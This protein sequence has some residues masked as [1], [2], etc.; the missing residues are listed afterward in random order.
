MASARLMA[1]HFF[2]F[3]LMPSKAGALPTS[4]LARKN[5]ARAARNLIPKSGWY[6]AEEDSL[7]LGIDNMKKLYNPLRRSNPTAIITT[8]FHLSTMPR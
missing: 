4:T 7:T 6:K 8:R 3:A 2:L 1:N 5:T